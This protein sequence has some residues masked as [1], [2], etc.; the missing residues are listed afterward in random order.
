MSPSE[1]PSSPP[2]R[3][4]PREP[5]SLTRRARRPRH[6]MCLLKGCESVYRP[7]HPLARYCRAVCRAAARQWR[8]WK[9]QQ[10]YRESP[11]GRQ[12][13]Q[14]QCRRNR[15]RRKAKESARKIASAGTARVIPIGFFSCDRPGCYRV[16]KRTKRSPQQ[17][18]C[19]RACRLALERVLK[20][21]RRWLK[22]S[23]KR[24]SLNKGPHLSGSGNPPIS[25]RRIER[26]SATSE[27]TVRTPREKPSAPGNDSVLSGSP[28]TARHGSPATQTA[29]FVA[30]LSAAAKLG[31]A[32]RRKRFRVRGTLS[33]ASGNPPFLLC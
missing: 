27:N 11:N 25:F 10:R 23:R 12:K 2:E 19:S 32:A 18:F 3:Q 24:K 26:L 6:R 13:R 33:T 9:A 7:Q 17:R 4:R 14:A 5:T 28:M 16:F 8:K 15:E 30:R 31:L 29:P 22:G 20:R 1:D 21:E